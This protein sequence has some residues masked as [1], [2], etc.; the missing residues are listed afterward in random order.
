[1]SRRELAPD[2]KLAM[3]AHIDL[4]IRELKAAL[5][6][7]L[8]SGEALMPMGRDALFL[9]IRYLELAGAMPVKR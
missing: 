7:E 3:V 5:A 9:L 2:Q 8:S 4:A 6:I 1:M